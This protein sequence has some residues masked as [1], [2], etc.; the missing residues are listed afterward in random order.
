MADRRRRLSDEELEQALRDLGSRLDYPTTD[1]TGPVR[2]RL[3]EA[4]ARSPLSRR[5][6]FPL[7]RRAAVATLALVLLASTILGFSPAARSAVAGWLGL[8]GIVIVREPS[9]PESGK[10]SKLA[11]SG[12]QLGEK[13]TMAQ[14][15]HRAPYEVVEPTLPVLGDPD[16][17]YLQEPPSGGQIALVYRARPGIP[18]ANET[19][20]GVLFTEFRGDLD[21]EAFKK[22]VGP[23]TRV[24]AVD[25][26]GGRGYWLTGR[27]HFFVYRGEDG[28]LRKENIRLAGNTLIWV[29]EN[30]TLRLES[31]LPKG[32]ALRIAESVR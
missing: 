26:G 10:E 7:W 21:P 5:V 8:E 24:E 16:E 12:L 4:P 3:Q 29:Q 13:R 20:V 31:D 1:L 23:G 27:P 15:R 25:V 32:E 6:L 19:G 11:G 9:M 28:V 2:Q 18:R 14:A 17:V 30:L 22:I